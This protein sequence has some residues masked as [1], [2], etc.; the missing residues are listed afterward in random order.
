M[1]LYWWAKVSTRFYKRVNQLIYDW[2]IDL[3]SMVRTFLNINSLNTTN[4][5]CGFVYHF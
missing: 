1:R 3:N 5:Q 4:V 2:L